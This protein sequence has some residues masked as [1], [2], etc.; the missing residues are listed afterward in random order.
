MLQWVKENFQTAPGQ[1]IQ[2]RTLGAVMAGPGGA[3]PLPP[4]QGEPRTFKLSG[5]SIA[6]PLRS[7]A[8][9]HCASLKMTVLKGSITAKRNEEAIGSFAEIELTRVSTCDD[10][11][12]PLLPWPQA[13]PS[14]FLDGVEVPRG[15]EQTFG[16]WVVEGIQRVS[17][18]CTSRGISKPRFLGRR[19]GTDHNR[20]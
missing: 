12:Q 15:W 18:P 20:P 6:G 11:A 5:G 9:T 10:F 8:G 14:L 2:L 19:R 3:T 4:P 1:E 7:P 16:H 13:K 17:I